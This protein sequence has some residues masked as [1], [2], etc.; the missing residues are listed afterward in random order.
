MHTLEK[1]VVLGAAVDK[2]WDFVATP[3]NLNLLT[4]PELD[5]R[6]VSKVPERMFDGLT[7]LYDIR[8]PFFGRR[9]WLSE[10]KHIREGFSFVDEQRIGPYRY[11]YHY[12]QVEEL[13]AGRS[14]MLDRVHYRLPAEPF[15]LPLHALVV[16]RMLARI[17]AY[18]EKR[19]QEIF[20]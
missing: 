10:I 16:E 11:W 6:I 4:P 5:F 17:F 3:D 2:L 14:R 12:H 7:I 20:P 15:S 19:L 13:G 8:I 1:E 18:R 9:R